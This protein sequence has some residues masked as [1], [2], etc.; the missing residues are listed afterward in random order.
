[1][2]E[3]TNHARWARWREHVEP[4]NTRFEGARVEA[5][6]QTARWSAIGTGQMMRGA[7]DDPTFRRKMERAPLAFY[8][9]LALFASPAFATKASNR[10]SS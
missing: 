10:G 4:G 9:F 5:A 1:M 3:S 6:R 8:F 2:N 7:A